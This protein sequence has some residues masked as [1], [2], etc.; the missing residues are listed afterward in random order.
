MSRPA[1]ESTQSPIHGLTQLFP[2]SECEVYQSTVVPRLRMR[3][4]VLELPQWART[5]LLLRTALFRVIKQR[6]VVT[7]YRLSWQPKSLKKGPIGCPESR[8]EITTTRCVITQK[9][10]FSSAS[11]RKSE[12]TQLYMIIWI[13]LLFMLHL[14]RWPTRKHLPLGVGRIEIPPFRLRHLRSVASG[15]HRFSYVFQCR[16]QWC[17]IIL[18]N[19]S[20]SNVMKF[21]VLFLFVQHVEVTK[22]RMTLE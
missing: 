14:C 3:R 4:F 19:Q 1:L 2:R 21:L 13:C 10:Q 20:C 15:S 16:W 9:G 17:R 8:Q 18:I 7:S 22:L 11:Q 6:G 5:T 12:I